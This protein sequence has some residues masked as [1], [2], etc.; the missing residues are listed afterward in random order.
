[1]KP[2]L[3]V[4]IVANLAGLFIFVMLVFAIY[5]NAK[6]EERDYYDFGDSLNFL[7]TAVPVFLLCSLLNAG[8]LIK[9]VVQAVRH[10]P[11]R[12]DAIACACSVTTWAGTMLLLK[13]TH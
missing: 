10:R 13:A 6:M 1:M 9:A 11:W 2:S 12:G 3:I 4:Y 8:W 5:D 7:V